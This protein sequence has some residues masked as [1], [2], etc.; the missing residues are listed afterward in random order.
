MTT[1]TILSCPLCGGTE[2]VYHS[3]PLPNLYS[4]KMA[5]ITGVAECDLLAHFHNVICLTCG[6]IYKKEAFPPLVI[7][8][9]FHDIIPDHPKG[10]DVMSGRFTADNFFV[11]LHNYEIAIINQDNEQENRYRRALLSIVDSIYPHEP[12]QAFKTTLSEALIRKDVLYIRTQEEVIRG[13]INQPMPFK[14]FS[15][16]SAPELWRYLVSTVGSLNQYDELGCP[17]WGLLALAKSEGIDARFIQRDELNYWGDGCRKNNI[18]CVDWLSN[19]HSVPVVKWEHNKTVDKRQMVGFFQY[20]DHLENP[21]EFLEIIFSKYQ[22][23]AVILD[24]VDE[25]VYIQHNTGWT[26]E[27]LDFVAN[28]FDK[29]IHHGFSMI[30][31]SGNRLYVFTNK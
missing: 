9:I 15:G 10:W 30:E 29:K 6:L 24:G 8:A 21:L 19:H 4:E 18:H 7:Q 16:F 1:D 26:N 17:L 31:P 12:H 28:R 22:A 25:P 13:I 14:R 2:R 23:A 27:A 5:V 3:E 20:L 11:E